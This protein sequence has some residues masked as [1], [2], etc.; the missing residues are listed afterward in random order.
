MYRDVQGCL[1]FRIQAGRSRAQALDV[2]FVGSGSRAQSTRK[3]RMKWK[4]VI[5]TGW[6]GLEVP[7]TSGPLFGDPYNKHSSNLGENSG[8]LFRQLECLQNRFGLP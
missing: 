4:L 6:M 8:L 2:G 3:W 5:Y 1:V 7:E